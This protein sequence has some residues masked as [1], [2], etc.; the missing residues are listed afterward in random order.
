MTHLASTDDLRFRDEFEARAI[1]KTEF[2]HRQHLRLAYVYLTEGGAES[3]H[4]RVRAAL[5]AFISH[6][7]IP[8]TKYNETLTRAW[9]LAVRHFMEKKDTVSFDEL[10]DAHPV[11][12]DSRIMHTHYTA[13]R[14][15]TDEARAGFVEPDLDPIPRYRN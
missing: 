5:H 3:A 9:V 11:L 1:P 15:H 7:G 10:I 12:L 14:L 4:K 13:D 6:H 2:K 8:P